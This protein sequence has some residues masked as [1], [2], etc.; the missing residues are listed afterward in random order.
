MTET[1][2]IRPETP[3]DHAAIREINRLAFGQDG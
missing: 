1:L 3:E 2:L